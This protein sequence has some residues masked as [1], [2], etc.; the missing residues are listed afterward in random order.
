MVSIV[1]S[2][3][4]FHFTHPSIPLHEKMSESQ[5]S[6]HLVKG[7]GSHEGPFVYQVLHA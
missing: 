7:V 6:A 3:E 1:S 4:R 2:I 5:G